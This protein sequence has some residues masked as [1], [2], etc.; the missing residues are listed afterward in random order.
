MKWCKEHHKE[1]LITVFMVKIDLWSQ[2]EWDVTIVSFQRGRIWLYLQTSFL[3]SKNICMSSWGIRTIFKFTWERKVIL[4]Q[5]CAAAQ[6]MMTTTSISLDR[7]LMQWRNSVLFS[8]I[9]IS[10]IHKD[11]V[12]HYFLGK[13]WRLLLYHPTNLSF[14]RYIIIE[15]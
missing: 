3:Q 2:K 10:L 14:L 12:K 11:V 8:A 1:S 5:R 13:F 9:N 4:L 6:K 7:K 15:W